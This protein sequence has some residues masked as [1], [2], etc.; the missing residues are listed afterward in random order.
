MTR[1][2]LEIVQPVIV[3]RLEQTCPSL[4][5]NEALQS[6]DEFLY[7]WGNNPPSMFYEGVTDTRIKSPLRQPQRL[8]GREKHLY[9]YLPIRSKGKDT[10]AFKTFYVRHSI[11]LAILTL[12][13]ETLWQAPHR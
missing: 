12:A 2:I 8:K 4:I 6:N 1:T 10:H 13:S 9:K 11:I 5:I 3:I 7:R